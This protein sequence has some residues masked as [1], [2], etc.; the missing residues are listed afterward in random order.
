L[1]LSATAQF[2]FKVMFFSEERREKLY[3]VPVNLFSN[4]VQ[5]TPRERLAGLRIEEEPV[6]S[7]PEGM[8][9]NPGVDLLLSL[10]CQLI[11][12]VALSRRS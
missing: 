3:V 9:S 11:S 7:L 4:H 6:T 1:L 12:V 5:P 8:L 10:V 2:D